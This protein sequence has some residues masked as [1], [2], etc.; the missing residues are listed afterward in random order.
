MP[1]LTFVVGPIGGGI[2]EMGGQLAQIY[3]KQPLPE[4]FDF[5]PEYS[6]GVL[7]KY[8]SEFAQGGIEESRYMCA[9]KLTF[10]F[11]SY[12]KFFQDTVAKYATAD[13]LVLGGAGLSMFIAFFKN[14]YPDAEI[15]FVKRELSRHALEAIVNHTLTPE[16]CWC[17]VEHQ[18]LNSEVVAYIENI[19]TYISNCINELVSDL[20]YDWTT[21]NTGG[22]NE[23]EINLHNDAAFMSPIMLAVYKPS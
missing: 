11:E 13:H 9:N 14:L 1:K 6:E 18:P 3:R 16:M 10:D 2:A 7:L 17:G 5:P 22:I 15:V 23:S 12:K 21:K 19:N 20:G 8:M 4:S